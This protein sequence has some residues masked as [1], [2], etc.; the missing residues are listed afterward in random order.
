MFATRRLHA[1][2]ELLLA[3]F[4]IL[5]AVAK[6]LECAKED[7]QLTKE[8]NDFR[9]SQGL[10]RIPVS[11]HLTKVARFHT[12]V[13][14]SNY[15]DRSCNMHSWGED[16]QS[17]ERW[18]PCCYTSDHAEAAC[19]WNKPKELTPYKGNGYEI[20]AGGYANNAAAIQGWFKSSGHRV[21]M[22]SEGS[23]SRINGAIGCAVTDRLY[24]CWFGASKDALDVCDDVVDVDELPDSDS[25]KG[26][27]DGG[28]SAGTV[29]AILFSICAASGALFYYK[30]GGW[31]KSI[32][33]SNTPTNPADRNQTNI[34]NVKVAVTG[35]YGIQPKPSG[36]QWNRPSPQLPSGWQRVKDDASGDFYY[37]NE[38]TD[39][40][41]WD[42]PASR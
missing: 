22:L 33:A 14:K 1:L 24:H 5:L 39:E 7:V 26:G 25:G 30:R 3:S 20:S 29:I 38:H 6:G 13:G 18:S 16:S 23:W 4:G 17:P 41:S 37:W 40:T 15:E 34:E 28:S 31:K 11:A 32:P 10:P 35:A 8:L 12:S 19:M 36:R 27:S 2:A 42:A 9:A 21:V